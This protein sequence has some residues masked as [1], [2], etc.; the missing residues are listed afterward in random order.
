MCNTQMFAELEQWRMFAQ[1]T[2]M[3]HAHFGIFRGPRSPAARA[4]PPITC[5]CI[6]VD[7]SPRHSSHLGRFL[8]DIYS[9][10]FT[11]RTLARNVPTKPRPAPA[12]SVSAVSGEVEAEV[13]T[14]GEACSAACACGESPDNCSA[15]ERPSPEEAIKIFFTTRSGTAEKFAKSLLDLLRTQSYDAQVS[16]SHV[17][18]IDLATYEPDNLPSEPAAIFILPTYTGGA[19]LPSTLTFHEWLKENSDER[20]GN[21]LRSTKAAVFGLGNREYQAYNAV[22]RETFRQLYQVI[23]ANYIDGSHT[24]LH[25]G[26][27]R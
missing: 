10:G 25:F 9:P 20:G 16:P 7:Y 15:C 8:S 11:F 18:I 2:S 3:A 5:C 21:T 13:E 12:Q 14:A 22:G 6:Y 19:P 27:W 4:A 26:R 24:A 1:S 17:Q 23:L